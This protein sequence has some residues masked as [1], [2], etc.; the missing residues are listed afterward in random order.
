MARNFKT[1]EAT[2]RPILFPLGDDYMLQVLKQYIAQL[3][4]SPKMLKQGTN[5]ED[6]SA[7][8]HLLNHKAGPSAVKLKT[9]GVFGQK[10]AAS[11][12]DFQRRNSL[13]PDGVVGPKTKSKL[14]V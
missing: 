12:F 5:G 13:V 14:T 9:D 2:F 3:N 4:G 8:Q 11:V 7:L 10:T 6:V 1:V